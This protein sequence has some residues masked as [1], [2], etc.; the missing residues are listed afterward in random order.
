MSSSIWTRCAG[1]SEIRSLRLDPWRAVES[2]EHVPTRK[3][4]DSRAEQELLEELI[5]RVKP[6]APASTLHFLLT[7]PFRYRPLPHGSRFGKRFEGGIWYGS[8]LRETT[9]AEVAYYRLLFL[10]GTTADISPVMR[11]LT[12]FRVTARSDHGIDLTAAPFDAH[13]PAIASPV[14][15]DET[16]ALGAA[17]RSAGVELL[18]FPSARAPGGVN[19]AAFTPAVFG[20]SKPRDREAWS[21]FA[22]HEA[23][24]FFGDDES[25]S[26]PRAQFLV[27]GRLP[28]PAL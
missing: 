20:R 19:V 4:V 18:R 26:F 17:M 16:Q 24:D 6:P 28:A 21:C 8:E 7:T 22:S 11:Q 10:A 27:D 1:K 9:F 23:V 25:F 15:Y 3:L 14:S 13:R 5:D 12:L 2:Q